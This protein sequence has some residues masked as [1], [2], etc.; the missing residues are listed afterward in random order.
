MYTNVVWP[1]LGTTFTPSYSLCTTSL[2]LSTA[3]LKENE[4]VEATKMKKSLWNY[5]SP[6][7]AGEKKICSW[8][9]K[10]VIDGILG[11]R[12]VNGLAPTQ[13]PVA[14]TPSEII[15]SRPSFPLASQITMLHATL[16]RTPTCFL[17]AFYTI[18]AQPQTN[19]SC[20]CG[21]KHWHH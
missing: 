7:V 6:E 13:L 3:F 15:H 4:I 21:S 2:V 8:S 14:G 10:G 1:A 19:S 20:W 5:E 17:G 18:V 12:A 9:L 11:T 16:N